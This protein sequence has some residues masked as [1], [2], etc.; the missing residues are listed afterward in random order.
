[1]RILDSKYLFMALLVMVAALIVPQWYEWTKVIVFLVCFIYLPGRLF[2]FQMEGGNLRSLTSIGVGI[3]I[4]IGLF[5]LAQWNDDIRILIIPISIMAGCSLWKLIRKTNGM[6]KI[7]LDYAQGN[8][9]LLALIIISPYLLVGFDLDALTSI[10]NVSASDD[11]LYHLSLIKMFQENFPIGSWGVYEVKDSIIRYHYFVHLLLAEI[12]KIT[13]T[14]PEFMYFRAFPYLSIVAILSS[15]FELGKVIIKDRA[16]AVLGAYLSTF[17]AGASVLLGLSGAVYYMGIENIFALGQKS[18]IAQVIGWPTI[19][20]SMFFMSLLTILLFDKTKKSGYMMTVLIL[21]IGLTGSKGSTAMMFVGALL[22]YGIVFFDKEFMLKKAVPMVVVFLVGYVVLY[23]GSSY[24]EANTGLHWFAEMTWIGE[25]ITGLKMVVL[26]AGY[27]VGTIG[28]RFLVL[29]DKDRNSIV[30]FVKVGLVIGIA[31]YIVS[32]IAY[33]NDYWLIPFSSLSGILIVDYV[34]K[35]KR[36]WMKYGFALLILAEILFGFSVVSEMTQAKLGDLAKSEEEY[37]AYLYISENTNSDSVVWDMSN[38][39]DRS[40]DFW[41]IAFCARQNLMS[42]W[43][44]SALANK[45]QEANEIMERENILLESQ[46]INEIENV[47][48]M[49]PYVDYLI[50]P[51]NISSNLDVMNGTSLDKF[52]ENTDIVIYAVEGSGHIGR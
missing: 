30:R 44:F 11:I 18:F 37:E 22:C 34:F 13:N 46:D 49:Y 28:L 32:P 1:M 50:Y 42:G 7:R 6:P 5:V 3:V 40:H 20:L 8:M 16:K 31:L 12:S 43:A 19:A 2:T 26:L 52:F 36:T 24:V 25:S 35:I 4:N 51:K 27:L 33:V 41:C 38:T 45:D 23:T 29:L 17:G 10:N 39:D 9:V 14:S 15:M 48:N 21:M 47:V